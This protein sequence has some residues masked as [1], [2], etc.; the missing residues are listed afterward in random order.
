M[1]DYEVYYLCKNIRQRHRVNA[2]RQEL[3]GKITDERNRH[4]ES[5]EQDRLVGNIIL[6]NKAVDHRD[7]ADQDKY[8]D[9][10][11]SQCVRKTI[12]LNESAHAPV[13]LKSDRFVEVRRVAD[14]Q[15]E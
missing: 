9:D 14:R 6:L 10:D 13:D 12:Y 3:S 5:Q 8:R 7:S 1:N 4:R 2:F 11:I 15:R